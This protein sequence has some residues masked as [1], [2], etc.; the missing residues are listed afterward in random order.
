VLCS[1]MPVEPPG[2]HFLTRVVETWV[3]AYLPLALLVGVGPSAISSADAA[4]PVLEEGRVCPALPISYR[5]GWSI[6]PGPPP[7]GS[8]P[9][10]GMSSHPAP[11][12]S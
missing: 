11:E 5:R 1:L 3:C 6:Y 10:K 7:H 2:E 4:R 12:C 9:P 8:L